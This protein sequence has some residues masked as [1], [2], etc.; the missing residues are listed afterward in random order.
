MEE[1]PQRI[2]LPKTPTNRAIG[3]M[4]CAETICTLHKFREGYVC[5]SCMKR[6]KDKIRLM[7]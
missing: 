4:F 7:K 1:K 5:D 6:I 3:C 2:K